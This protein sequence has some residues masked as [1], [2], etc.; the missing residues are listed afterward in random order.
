VDHGHHVCH[1]AESVLVCAAL[2]LHGGPF[3]DA[4]PPGIGVVVPVKGPATKQVICRPVNVRVWTDAGV[5]VQLSKDAVSG[6]ARFAD[7]DYIAGK[8]RAVSESSFECIRMIIRLPTSMLSI[9]ATRRRS[10]SPG[11]SLGR[12]AFEYSPEAGERMDPLHDAELQRDWELARD[13]KPL[14]KVAPLE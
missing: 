4:Q 7:P 1:G 8:S 13:G 5:T 2:T 11:M 12:F 14:E 9:K 6:V 10:I 3:E